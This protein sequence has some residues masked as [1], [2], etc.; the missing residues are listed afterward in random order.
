MAN[1]YF[2]KVSKKGIQIIPV[3]LEE[4]TP[5]TLI[6]LTGAVLGGMKAITRG[7]LTKKVKISLF[8]D[9]MT[10]GDGIL[11]GINGNDSGIA[12]GFA[13]GVGVLA[14]LLDPE[15]SDDY[16][17]TEEVVKT[18][19][20]ETVSPQIQTTAGGRQFIDKMI[21]IGGGKGIPSVAGAGPEIFAFNPAAFSLTTPPKIS[22]CVTFYGVWLED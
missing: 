8:I 18:V 20:H 3:I 2:G 13:A 10:A 6:K 5:G 7:F 11:I 12:G 4:A 14:K 21:S 22:G 15:A 9:G 16:L 17:I 19:W 1:E